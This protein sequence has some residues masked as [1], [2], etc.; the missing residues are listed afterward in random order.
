MQ[1]ADSE[2]EWG[3]LLKEGFG[4]ESETQ[5]G[6]RKDRKGQRFFHE[7]LKQLQ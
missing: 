3:A 4:D 2:E 6:K 7:P 5:G 1:R